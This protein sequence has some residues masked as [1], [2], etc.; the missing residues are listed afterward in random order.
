MAKAV[1]GLFDDR[2]SAGR[3][4]RDLQAMGF[5]R[6]DIS[7]ALRDRGDQAEINKHLETGDP[8]G[9]AGV[10]ATGGTLL[11]GLAGLLVG[12]GALAIPGIGPVLAIGPL[13]AAIGTGA[14]AAGATALGAGI[15]AAAGGIVGALVGMGVPKEDAEFYAEGVKRGGILVTV[16]TDDNRADD[17][18]RLMRDAGSIDVDTERR[19]WRDQGWDRFDESRMPGEGYPRFTRHTTTTEPGY[20]EPTPSTSY[21][22]TTQ[23]SVVTPPDYT[24]PDR[25]TLRPD[26]DRTDRPLDRPDD[27]PRGGDRI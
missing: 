25:G 1:V 13:S 20:R 8:A 6:D 21:E 5:G 22:R 16:R 10:G 2:A 4:V 23:G 15:G 18:S 27:Y 3:A 11:G 7:V 24:D 17:V 12:I 9:G 26:R 19:T 14:A